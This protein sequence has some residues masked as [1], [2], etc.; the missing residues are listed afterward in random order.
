MSSPAY[1]HCRVQ[2]TTLK[3]IIT[4]SLNKTNLKKSV[5]R[6]V[7]LSERNFKEMRR[8][9][10]WF[11]FRVE[12]TSLCLSLSL[13]CYFSRRRNKET[14]ESE[15]FLNET[16]PRE[17]MKKGERKKTNLQNFSPGNFKKN[18]AVEQRRTISTFPPVREGGRRKTSIILII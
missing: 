2:R 1:S 11:H 17:R 3:E 14:E 7:L 15:K 13:R 18:Y 16:K 5:S 12:S 9:K 4:E 10:V 8:K 6:A